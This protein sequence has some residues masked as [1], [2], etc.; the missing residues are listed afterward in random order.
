MFSLL[1]K[2]QEESWQADPTNQ[3]ITLSTPEETGKYQI[4]STYTIEPE[5]YYITT[6]FPD[7]TSY[8]EFLNTIGSR[9]NHDYGVN[10]TKN[11]TILTLSSCTPDAKKRIV[12]HAK[13]L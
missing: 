8:E 11:D 13:K 2:T 5:E 1:Y 6:D 12:V 9:S 3:I 4:F 10:L 7:D